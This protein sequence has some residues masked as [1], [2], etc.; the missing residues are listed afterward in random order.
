[1]SWPAEP[2]PEPD[3]EDPRLA[4]ALAEER[5][6]QDW[7]RKR[8]EHI[9]LVGTFGPRL[10][11]EQLES[12]LQDLV[13]AYVT[14]NVA[15]AELGSPFAT[16]HGWL[17]RVHVYPRRYF[18]DGGSIRIFAVLPTRSSCDRTRLRTTSVARG[19]GSGTDW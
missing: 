7:E 9:P 1:M 19:R 13:G 12:A 8:W 15:V 2:M 6:R 3:S 14:A 10:D 4:R 5:R 17:N 18:D 11:F 16:F